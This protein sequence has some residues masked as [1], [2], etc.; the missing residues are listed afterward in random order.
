M[1]LAIL[2]DQPVQRSS[3]AAIHSL[4]RNHALQ[5]DQVNINDRKRSLPARPTARVQPIGRQRFGYE[6][7]RSAMRDLGPNHDVFALGSQFEWKAANG[8]DQIPP[9][10]DRH[11]WREDRVVKALLVSLEWFVGRTIPNTTAYTIGA[12]RAGDG[13]A[14]LVHTRCLRVNHPDLRIALQNAHLALQFVMMPQVV[15]I[16]ERDIVS[17]TMSESQ[18][19]SGADPQVGVPRVRQHAHFGRMPA[20]VA[21]SDGQAVVL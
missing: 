7:E 10:Q 20:G 1:L 16:E 12:R 2:V 5:I 4:V 15:R 19:A 11:R 6:I 17:L 13:M 14:H 8:L 3:D 9:S 21:E 18:I